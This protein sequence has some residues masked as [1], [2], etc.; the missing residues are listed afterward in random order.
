MSLAFSKTEP[1]TGASVVQPKVLAWFK[2]QA[3]A[4]F[5]PVRVPAMAAFEESAQRNKAF[6]SELDN[7]LNGRGSNSSG[8]V[9]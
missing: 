5:A 6:L 9:Q 3:E 4:L 2:D 1:K 8:K 7:V